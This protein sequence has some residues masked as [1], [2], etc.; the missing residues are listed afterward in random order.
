MKTTF[1][2]AKEIVSRIAAGHHDETLPVADMRFNELKSLEIAGQ[3]V[4]VLP[5]AQR[6]FSGR[7]RIPQSYLERCSPELQAENLNFWLERE[8][9]KRETLFCRFD[10]SRMRAVFTDRYKVIDNA[11][12]VEKMDEY[13]FPESAEV[14]LSLDHNLMALKVP[15]YTRSFFIGKDEITPGIAIS[16]SEVGVLAFSIEAYFYRLVCTNGLISQTEITSKFRHV[17][18]K[19]LED[20]HGLIGGVVAESKRHEARFGIT[21]EKEVKEPLST[22][23]SFNR[24]FQLTK[25]EGQAVEE[26]WA[27]EQG[28]TMFHVIN[29]YTRGAQNGGLSVEESNRLERVGGQ[30]LSL[31]K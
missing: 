20:F 4:E 22:I 11:E 10:G 13:G 14:H 8:K 1:G 16:N 30:I 29:A 27:A 5:S 17:S 6:L 7:L 9:E 15:D 25:K 12:I 3:K 18:Y 31:I 2:Q 28:Y 19:A 21:V 26:A 23:G 24:Q